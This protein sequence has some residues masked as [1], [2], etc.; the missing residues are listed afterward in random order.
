MTDIKIA[1]CCENEHM[2]EDIFSFDVESDDTDEFIDEMVH[3]YLFN[4]DDSFTC[5]ICNSEVVTFEWEII[6]DYN[7]DDYSELLYTDIIN[8]IMDKLSNLLISIP[9]AA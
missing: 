2:H 9:A 7:N 3:D 6:T 5:N 8:D 4:D 1:W